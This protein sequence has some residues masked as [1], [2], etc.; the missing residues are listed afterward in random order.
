MEGAPA[1]SSPLAA[2]RQIEH[3]PSDKIFAADL[4]AA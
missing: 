4:T 2:E 1:R 3:E